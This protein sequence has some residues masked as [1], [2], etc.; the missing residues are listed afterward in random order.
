MIEEEKLTE[1]LFEAPKIDQQERMVEAILF[2]SSDPV[3]VKE[4]ISRLPHGCEPE[5]RSKT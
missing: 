5:R 2:A 4:I 3:S 1:S